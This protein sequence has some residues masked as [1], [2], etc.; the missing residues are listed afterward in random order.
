VESIIGL[1]KDILSIVA[2]GKEIIIQK[3]DAFTQLP[4]T[5]ST[6]GL[7]LSDAGCTVVR[8]LSTQFEGFHAL[9]MNLSVAIILVA[10]TVLESPSLARASTQ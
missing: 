7:F 5:F 2:K 3:Q 10:P 8:L 4:N 9:V 1:K 6:D